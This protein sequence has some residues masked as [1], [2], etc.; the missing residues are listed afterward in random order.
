MGDKI[1]VKLEKNGK[2]WNVKDIESYVA[3]AEPARKVESKGGT[4]YAWQGREGEAYDRSAAIY[5]AMDIVKSTKTEK[6]LQKYEPEE[7]ASRLYSLAEDIFGYINLGEFKDQLQV[8]GD[9]PL[10]PP[11]V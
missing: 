3:P 11:K 9:D 2:Y 8:S 7:L 1:N 5:L 4:G 6:D 10:E